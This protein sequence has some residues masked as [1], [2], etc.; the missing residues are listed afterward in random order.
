[1]VYIAQVVKVEGHKCAHN[2]LQA[3][4]Y[5]LVHASRLGA[6]LAVRATLIKIQH[7]HGSELCETLTLRLGSA[8]TLKPRS[9]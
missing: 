9:C 4:G 2:I 8:L 7:G 5:T 3:Y 1:M 6:S